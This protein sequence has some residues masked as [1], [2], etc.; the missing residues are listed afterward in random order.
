M[1]INERAK[2]EGFE[3]IRLKLGGDQIPGWLHV[4]NYAEPLDATPG[5]IDQ[6]LCTGVVQTMPRWMVVNLLRDW[7]DKLRVQGLLAIEMP[8]LDKAIL[9]RERQSAGDLIATPLGYLNVGQWALY[10]DQWEGSIGN[11]YVWTVREFVQELNKAG[12]YVKEASHD[13]KFNRKGLDMWVV[14]ERVA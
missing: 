1:T 2:A 12:F 11:Q 5:S 3:V 6:I 8:D 10:G 9:L 14:A 13:A 7:Y 4:E